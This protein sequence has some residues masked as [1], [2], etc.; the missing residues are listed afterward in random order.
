M[1]ALREAANTERRQ[2]ALLVQPLAL[3]V[4]ALLARLTRARPQRRDSAVGFS[5]VDG[6]TII[7]I[8]PQGAVALAALRVRHPAAALPADADTP[9]TFS[10]VWTTRVG[11]LPTRMP[12]NGEF[13]E[14]CGCFRIVTI[15]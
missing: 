2:R 1:L 5:S 7:H 10:R 12:T 15:D 4:L 6:L 14:V 11:R 9:L 3:I 13:A 8:G